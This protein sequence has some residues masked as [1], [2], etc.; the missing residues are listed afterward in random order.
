[1]TNVIALDD[2]RTAPPDGGFIMDL[3]LAKQRGFR[4]TA[5]DVRRAD[6]G[7]TEE[8]WYASSLG[9]CYRQQYMQ[10]LG[11]E[12]LRGID[13]DALRTFA[14][15][16][17]IEAFI[18]QMYQRCGLVEDT[19]MRLQHGSLVARGDLLL[20]YPPKPVE[21]IPDDVRSGWSPEW[22]AFLA[23]LRAEV[24]RSPFTGLVH[25][26]IKSTHSRA[27]KFLFKEGKPRESH[28]IQ[29]GCSI[30][31]ESL[32]AD[33]PQ[34]DFH[35][36]EYLGKDSVG[37]LRFR[38]GDEWAEVARKRWE[39]LDSAWDAKANPMDVECE[40]GKAKWMVTYCSYYD[41]GTG[42]C[43]GNAGLG[44]SSLAIEDPF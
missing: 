15:G 42:T 25:S 41:G 1:M 38:V 17:H 6:A 31:L 27:M 21:T 20:R 2:A 3:Y 37:L 28:S 11:I 19:Q 14:W 10:R 33:A 22:L 36:V 35:Q 8:G 29:V 7:I 24:A 16:D 12:R 23:D 39:Y 30:L 26:E 4:D 13:A 32:V 43:C 40:C 44:Q 34:P 5:R 9:S 18:V